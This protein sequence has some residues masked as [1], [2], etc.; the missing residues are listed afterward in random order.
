[1]Y[2]TETSLPDDGFGLQL[3]TV[4]ACFAP[5][6]MFN[7]DCGTQEGGGR[8]GSWRNTE[9]VKLMMTML[10]YMYA[11]YKPEDVGIVAIISPYRSQV[12]LVDSSN[13]C[14]LWQVF[15]RHKRRSP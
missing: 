11:K 14:R 12:L 13:L 9:E 5:F 4:Q 8:G 2:A 3:C 6:V 7:V 15:R 10:N 1:M